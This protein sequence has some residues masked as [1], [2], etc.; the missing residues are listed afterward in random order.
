[1]AA[2]VGFSGP[3]N[4]APGAQVGSARVL[5]RTVRGAAFAV[6]VSVP[7]P[8]RITIAGT[9][10]RTVAGSVA[11]AGRFTLRV[12]LTQGARRTLA[13]QQRLT[14]SLQ[15]VYAPPGAPAASARFRLTTLRAVSHPPRRARRSR[16]RR[17]TATAGR[18]SR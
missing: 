8:G 2:S 1:V 4:A 16:A 13:R 7:G 5:T 12:A 15:I 11:H 14:L 17:A 10:V 6:A 3:G 18:A 9:G